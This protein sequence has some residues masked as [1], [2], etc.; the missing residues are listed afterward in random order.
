MKK[1][2]VL[3]V[4]FALVFAACSNGTTNE[5]SNGTTLLIKNQSSKTIM[6]VLWN[7]VIFG[8]TSSDYFGTWKG[9]YTLPQNGEIEVELDGPSWTTVYDS[10]KDQYFDGAYSIV[11]KDSDSTVETASGFIGKRA[12]TMHNVIMPEND[13]FQLRCGN[14][15]LSDN[16]LILNLTEGAASSFDGFFPFAS[17]RQIYTLDRVGSP[18]KPGNNEIKTVTAGSGYIFFKFDLTEY[19]TVDM[20]NVEKSNGEEFTFINST[21]VVELNNPSAV[22]TLGSL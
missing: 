11:F 21:L 16:R 20:V 7:N 17:R 12:G 4:I 8:D 14:V 19:R 9:T 10:W 1:F 15:T 5:E 22:K 13:N 18:L 6:D 2:F 3:M